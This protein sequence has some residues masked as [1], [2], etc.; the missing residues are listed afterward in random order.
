MLSLSGRIDR[1]LNNAFE[2]QSK[3]INADIIIL[4]PS[5]TEQNANHGISKSY[6][7]NLALNFS[8]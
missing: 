6:L 3:E 7:I 1:E 8:S 4:T 2:L 5:E